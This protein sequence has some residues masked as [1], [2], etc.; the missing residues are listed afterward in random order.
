[1]LGT[2]PGSGQGNL[3]S[4]NFDADSHVLSAEIAS[5]ELTRFADQGQAQ[6]FKEI[7]DRFFSM[8]PTEPVPRSQLAQAQPPQTP[9]LGHN[10][11]HRDHTSAS[12]SPRDHM[13]SSLAALQQQQGSY[14]AM[15][16]DNAS[17]DADARNKSKRELSTSKRAAQ[18]RAAQVRLPILFTLSIVFPNTATASLPSKERTI[19]HRARGQS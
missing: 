15:S 18:N 4:V 12:A 1:M 11:E 10:S 6:K 14:D 19:H 7:R 3:Q 13:A 2:S 16:N 17:E 9:A 8:P 5:A